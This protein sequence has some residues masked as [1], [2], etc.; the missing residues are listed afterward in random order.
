[1]FEQGNGIEKRSM[2]RGGL[3]GSFFVRIEVNLISMILLGASAIVVMFMD[4]FMGSLKKPAA[5]RVRRLRNFFRGAMVLLKFFSPF[6]SSIQYSM[7]G[8]P[9]V[10]LQR[11]EFNVRVRGTE[12]SGKRFKKCF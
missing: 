9:Y 10:K 1:M 11:A 3:K 2:V 7:H 8:S 6:A 5:N 12:L 4:G